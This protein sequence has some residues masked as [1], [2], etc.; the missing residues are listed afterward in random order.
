M[1]HIH[2][3]IQRHSRYFRY[4]T[5][6]LLIKNKRNP[7]SL[8]VIF[9]LSYTYS[10]SLS[11]PLSRFL[12]LSRSLFLSP[13]SRALSL[14]NIRTNLGSDINISRIEGIFQF[15]YLNLIKCIVELWF[16]CR[17]MYVESYVECRMSTHD[18]NYDS[19]KDLITLRLMK[20]ESYVES[21]MSTLIH[22]S[23]HICRLTIQM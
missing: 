1:K 7:K 2:K 19:T 10:F 23:T 15:V 21:D 5:S 22:M 9:V 17:I 6:Q 20:R 4:G 18:V 16:I 14:F 8:S 13:L 12:S 3:H 11:L